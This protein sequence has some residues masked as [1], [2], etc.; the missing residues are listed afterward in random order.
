MQ[1]TP[2]SPPSP[3]TTVSEFPVSGEAL[4]AL[5]GASP[6]AVLKGM[7]AQ[8]DVLR[9]QLERVQDQRNEIARWLKAEDITAPDRDGLAARLKETDARISSLE[10]QIDQ[11][12]LAVSKAASVPGAVVEEPPPP[13]RSG[14]PDE[15]FAVPIV[16]TIF[17]LAP[18]AIAYARRI[19]KRGATVIA[20]IP[21]EVT[22]RLEQMGQSIESMA[23]EVER[24]GEGQRFL[25]RVM[26]EPG[27]ALGA[28]PAQPLVVPQGQKVSDAV[29]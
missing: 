6:T 13:P 17:V 15:I 16:F 23:I 28:G 5:E 25:T 10:K 2:P 22:D 18:I 21:R 12:D 3:P 27:K 7:E 4:K 9:D 19:W 24:I 29:R 8:R 14:P 11:A 26:S 1:P 20:P